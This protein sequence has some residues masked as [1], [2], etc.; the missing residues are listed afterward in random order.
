[1]STEQ[2]DSGAERDEYQSSQHSVAMTEEE[3]QQMIVLASRLR[4]QAGGELDDDAL[5]AVS[6]AT[7]APLDYIRLAVRSVPETT[8]KRTFVEQLRQSFLAF[9]PD[10]RRLVM[11]GVIGLGA[12][13][14]AFWS[15]A[16]PMGDP[17][18]FFSLLAT[19]LAIGG[20]YNAV[21]SRNVKTAIFAGALL[22]LVSQVTMALF[23]LLDGMLTPVGNGGS[24][25][26]A[27]IGL[28]ALGAFFGGFGYELFVKNRKKM[29]FGDPAAERHQLLTQL[30]EIQSK[31]KEDEKHVTFVS[32]DVVGSTRLKTENDAIEIEYTFNE[33]HKF[34]EQITLKYG[35][36][37]HST[38]GDGVTCVFE[39]P[40]S[41]VQA[42]KAMQAGLFEFN[43]FRNKLKA[44]LA[45]RAAVH[46]GAV[47]AP[48][49]ESTAVNFA[50]VIDVAAHLQK[51]GEPGTLVV[52]S[53][54][55]IYM[56]G[57]NAFGSERVSAEDVTAAVWRPTSSLRSADPK[58]FLPPLP[59]KGV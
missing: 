21:V 17:S 34:I 57:L 5:M 48:G 23:S 22:G 14:M 19:L 56:G 18:G 2:F 43:G 11:A 44:P 31:L 59:T 28:T 4:E 1:M 7:G 3:I 10:M 32:V 33:Y 46:T 9:D 25:P 50:H 49:R 41:A 16:L 51:V 13:F 54:T 37:I 47:L 35:G 53:T 26:L 55:A 6:E 12:G 58:S 29:G 36:Q 24:H 45:M 27:M 40:K 39:D 15:E 42:G 52:S 20:L 8:K 38:A 30:L